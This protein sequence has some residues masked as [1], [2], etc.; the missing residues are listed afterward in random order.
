MRARTEGEPGTRLAGL[1]GAASRALGSAALGAF[2]VGAVGAEAGALAAGT[3]ADTGTRG[4][5]DA[6]GEVASGESCQPRLSH[7]VAAAA[8]A[9]SST[10]NGQRERS[11]CER[12]ALR[13]TASRP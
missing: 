5:A 8:V 13:T 12:L 6:D 2:A 3:V 9:T 10:H 7:R 1:I 4:R 11:L